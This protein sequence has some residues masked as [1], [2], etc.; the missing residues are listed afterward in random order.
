MNTQDKFRELLRI[1]ASQRPEDVKALGSGLSREEILSVLKFQSVPEGLISIYSCVRGVSEKDAPHDLIPGWTLIAIDEL[2]Y[3]IDFLNPKV[4]AEQMEQDMIPFL[5][6]GCGSYY[7]I[8]SLPDDQSIYDLPKS[9]EFIKL[10]RDMDSF[11]DTSIACYREEAYYLD[12]EEGFWDIDY[13]KRDEIARR[14]NPGVKFW[15]DY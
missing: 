7:C 1:I 13:D 11:L 10:Y 8:R 9:D 14:F 2:N 12:E 15:E 5:F 4:Q 6:D 3:Y